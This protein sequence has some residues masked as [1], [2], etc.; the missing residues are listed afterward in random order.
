[1]LKS[2]RVMAGDI[3]AAPGKARTA[4][5]WHIPPTA[6]DSLAEHNI[7]RRLAFFAT[8]AFLFLKVSMLHEITAIVTG[9]LP[10]V[11]YVVVPPAVAGLLLSGGLQR[12]FRFGVTKIWAAYFVWL[13]L[14]VPF[15]YWVGGSAWAVFFYLRDNL[16]ILFLL[17]GTVVTPKEHRT[18]I[19]TIT[20]GISVMIVY[21][22]LNRNT[23]DRLSMG[24]GGTIGDPNDLAAHLL[25]FLPFLLFVIC[26]SD[27]AKLI[28]F[29]CAIMMA[30]GLYTLMRT[31]SRGGAVAAVVTIGMFLVRGSVRQRLATLVLVPPVLAGLLAIMPAETLRRL[32]SFSDEGNTTEEA[33]HSAE[34]RRYLL[35]RG[36]EFTRR[37]PVF[38]VGVGQFAN[39]EGKTAIESGM[40]GNWHVAH[41]T[42]IQASSES[43]FPALLLLLAAI[44][45]IFR[46]LALAYR[47]ARQR[48]AADTAMLANFVLIGFA[49]FSVAIAFLNF[50]L[51][52]HLPLLTGVVIVT[53]AV[54]ERQPAAAVVRLPSAGPG[55]RGW[56]RKTASGLDLRA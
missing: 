44:A 38:G 19:H 50:A 39:F 28:R 47:R 52:F 24:Y 48:G 5:V 45:G 26:R 25:L 16:I 30:G 32:T 22:L 2:S 27:T 49:G 1:M 53:Y 35:R 17:A 31:G 29:A 42:Y 7:V 37:Y 41:N 36:I 56:M 9:I 21:F 54:T 4:A 6:A 14:S 20:A 13:V 55:R 11:M 43:G 46:L 23:G 12:A 18:M 34:A 10:P 8:L 15:S 33:V 51:T 3:Q 40:R